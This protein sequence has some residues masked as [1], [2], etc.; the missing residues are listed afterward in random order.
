VRISHL[1]RVTL[2]KRKRKSNVRLVHS[3]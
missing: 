3:W 2:L 1:F